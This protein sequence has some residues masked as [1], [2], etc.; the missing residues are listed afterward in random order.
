MYGLQ[1]KALFLIFTSGKYLQVFLVLNAE[2]VIILLNNR[3]A[4]HF[5]WIL[6]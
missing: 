3:Y 5:Q 1:V 2:Q 6:T 4:I